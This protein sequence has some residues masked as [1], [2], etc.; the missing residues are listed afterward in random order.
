MSRFEG[1]EYLKKVMKERSGTVMKKSWENICENCLFTLVELLIVISIIAILASLLLPALKSA[2][3]KADEIKCA[4]NMKQQYLG[5][6]DYVN[7]FNGWLPPTRVD[8]ASEHYYFWGNY[9]N[10]N[11]LKQT[12]LFRCMNKTNPSLMRFW[13]GGEWGSGIST[14]AYNSYGYNLRP[15]DNYFPGTWLCSVAMPYSLNRFSSPS[16]TMIISEPETVADSQEDWYVYNSIPGSETNNHT[17]GF[18]HNGGKN[19]NVLYV[20]GHRQPV[21]YSWAVNHDYKCNT[22]EESVARV[23]WFG[24]TAGAYGSW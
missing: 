9:I 10:D 22:S 19:T 2:K 5:L 14:K 17:M 21:S 16:A 4:N 8:T 7:D 15:S 12:A 3:G 24:S 6:M 1:I 20:D 11:Y 23:F 18:Y 13:S